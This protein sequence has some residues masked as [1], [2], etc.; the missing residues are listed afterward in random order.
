[1]TGI[2]GSA[3]DI[4]CP[5]TP[6]RKRTAALCVPTAE[7]TSTTPKN[8]NRTGYPSSGSAILQ[9]M[10]VIESRR[11]AILL[12]DGMNVSG[13]PQRRDIRAGHPLRP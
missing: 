3:A 13:I 5:G 1:M 12:A 10:L 11:G 7:R 6:Q 8:E 4:I 9:I 2:E